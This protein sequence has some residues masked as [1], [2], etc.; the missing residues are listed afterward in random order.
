MCVCTQLRRAYYSPVREVG[1]LACPWDMDMTTWVGWGL[2]RNG[3]FA[4][5][6][7]VAKFLDG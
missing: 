4:A 5:G 1:A 2:T 3:V 7:V 6:E